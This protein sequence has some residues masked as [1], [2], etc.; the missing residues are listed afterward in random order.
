MP[1]EKPQRCWGIPGYSP[2]LKGPLSKAG[3][4][5]VQRWQALK[6]FSSW[7][8]SAWD[9]PAIFRNEETAGIV[10][11]YLILSKLSINI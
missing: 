2:G 7:A 3:W 4:A 5:Q 11:G 1:R 6:T 9:V 8:L 10:P